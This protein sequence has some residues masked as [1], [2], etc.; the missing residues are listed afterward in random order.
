[1]VNVGKYTIHGSYGEL[2]SV[3]KNIHYYGTSTCMSKQGKQVFFGTGVFGRE[4]PKFYSNRDAPCMDDLPTLCEQ[5]ATRTWG[6][7]CLYIFPSQN[8]ASESGKLYGFVMTR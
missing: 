3:N 5:M 6:N 2:S 8:T 1:M 4:I 7:G